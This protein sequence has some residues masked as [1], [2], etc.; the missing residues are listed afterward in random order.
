MHH[1]VLSGVMSASSR[2]P[3]LLRGTVRGSVSD[4]PVL[5]DSLSTDFGGL[6]RKRARVIVRPSCTEDVARVIGI[7]C[8]EGISVSTRGT[9]HSL[10]GQSLSDD[11]IL[12]DMRSLSSVH[13]VDAEARCFDADPGVAWHDLVS[14]TLSHGLLPPV[15]T[16]TLRTTL[17]GTHSV[18][19]IGHASFLYGTQA[20]NCL[21]LEVVTGNG[22]VRW[23]SSIHYPE[24][25]E[26]ALC[27]LGQLGVITRVQG[28]LRPVGVAVRHRVLVYAD[29]ARM[30]EDVRRAA[31]QR[32][33]DAIGAY[34]APRGG[35]WVYTIHLD[36]ECE[37]GDPPDARNKFAALRP[38]RIIT[39]PDRP[40]RAHLLERGS[41]SDGDPR[42]EAQ[43]GANPWVDAILPADAVEAYFRAVEDLLPTELL[44]RCTMIAWPLDGKR[45]TRPLFRRPA[46]DDLM[47][48]SFFP[49]LTCESLGAGAAIMSRVSELARSHGG[50]CYLY[51]WVDL[52]LD[53]WAGHFGEAWPVLARLKDRYDPDTVLN[54]G[55]IRYVTRVGC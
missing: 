10:S 1:E 35:K 32:L 53:A 54:P 30:L 50:T 43:P 24:L 8:S 33:G 34:G 27:G 25:F 46:V 40:V 52:D 37:P 7:A 3:A 38:D 18:G 4:S 51:G 39:V 19:G 48:A 14:R 11:G 31:A 29:R 47:V 42:N 16:A 45:L 41:V 23:C 21:G 6:V 17:G 20:D 12:L 9:G 5:L 28:R 2:L 13:V 49:V 44:S 36:S 15:L 55:F 26:H 22:E